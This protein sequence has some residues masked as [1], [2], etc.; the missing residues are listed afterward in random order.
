MTLRC[1]RST[2]NRVEAQ[3]VPHE[4]PA[5]AHEGHENSKRS[6]EGRSRS[7]KRPRCWDAARYLDCTG[8]GGDC[9]TFDQEGAR[10]FSD[11]TALEGDCT[12]LDGE[13]ADDNSDCTSVSG[14]C[15]DDISD[16]TADI[17]DCTKVLPDCTNILPGV[18]IEFSAQTVLQSQQL[19]SVPWSRKL[20]CRD[21]R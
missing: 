8:A 4:A 2:R 12:T 19:C 17:S 6:D 3:K 10:R 11:C 15:T 1:S 21:W 13:G 20:L 16:C 14:D 7:M 9:G 18:F 5:T